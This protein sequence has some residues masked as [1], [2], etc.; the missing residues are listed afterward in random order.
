MRTLNR[1]PK[2]LGMLLAFVVLSL[3]TNHLDAQTAV[4]QKKV[5]ETK[6]SETEVASKKGGGGTVTVEAVN[7]NGTAG[8]IARWMDSNTLESSIISQADS[9]IGIS[10]TT[11]TSKLTVNGRVESLS[12]GFRFPDGTT[13]TTAA[14]SGTGSVVHDGTLTGDGTSATPLGLALPLD[15][16]GT[17]NG[18]PL[19][20]VTN[21]GS[22]GSAILGI[23]S[24]NGNGVGGSSDV[25]R[26]VAGGS[27]SGPGVQGNSTSGHGVEGGSFSNAG[28][29]G[30]SA[31]FAGV[32]ALTGSTDPAVPSIRAL[33]GGNGFAG[34]FEGNVQV[35]GNLTKG[36]GSFKI[37]HPL[38]PENK[39][40]YHS[41]VE[42]PDM[43]NIYNGNVKL[44]ANG[45]AVVELPE[46]FGTLNKD[47][48]YSL[49]ALGAP[50][51]NLYIAAEVAD[52]QFKI[53]GGAP[54]MKIS[55]QVTG[56]RQDAWANKHRIPVEE[57][58][59]DTERGYY[60]HPELFNQPEEKGV[61]WARNPE[62]MQRMKQEREQIKQRGSK[63]TASKTSKSRL[64]GEGAHEFPG[65][66]TA[67]PSAVQQR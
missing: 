23:S 67:L 2:L 31:Q 57:Q 65:G 20:Q 49:T 11:P 45:E 16:N 21:N 25:G 33:N 59:S 15:L 24:S 61:E 14:T 54:G 26:G 30:T 34:K 64:A 12:G 53:A 22:A 28:V 50:G 51:P 63:S 55:W 35:T 58:K 9:K 44:D 18:L 46:W 66:A 27:T 1:K 3:N 6:A 13:Q 17:L 40:L 52:N 10:T 4:N 48:R 37:D 60:L 56:I 47:F 41:F 43:M 39:Y 5:S 32:I 62:M 29:S 8:H 19:I 42:S 36:G 38:D 7:G